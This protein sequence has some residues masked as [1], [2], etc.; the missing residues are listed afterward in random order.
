MITI[1]ELQ[2]AAQE[3]REIRHNLSKLISDMNPVEMVTPLNLTEAKEAWITKAEDG[4][5]E[6]PVFVYDSDLLV[7][8]TDKFGILD[9]ARQKI[10]KIK[11]RNE[12]EEFLLRHYTRVVTDAIITANMAK[13]MLQ[14]DDK[15]L[16]DSVILKY[17]RPVI[18]NSL[19]PNAQPVNVMYPKDQLQRLEN[20]SLDANFIKEIFIWSMEQYGVE[21][22]PV[23]I[24]ENCSAIDVRDKNSGGHP[25]IAIPASRKVNGLKLAELVGHEIECHWRNSQNITSIGCLKTDDE[26]VYEGVAKFKDMA[27]QAK[28]TGE[29][30]LPSIYHV[31]AESMAL[32]SVGFAGVGR[33]LFEATKSAK[34]AWTFTYRAF[35]G[36]ADTTNAVGYAFTK[37]KA[38][39]EGVICVDG[40]VKI[41]LLPYLSFAALCAGDIYDLAH[42]VDKA[43][44][45]DPSVL[46]DLDV[47]SKVL[48]E[49]E[50]RL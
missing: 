47:Q 46:R 23:E 26:V 19:N 42:S 22:W 48:S 31:L 25:M 27:F 34:R 11:P 2:G 16:S 44:I 1:K 12:A 45:F 35:R 24:L 13:A 28:T 30:T 43:S 9:E 5:F 8:I 50:R 49:V 38:Y 6:N 20:V 15:S 39:L 3:Y 7:K 14:K 36:V 37:D 10:S 4:H 21:P 29:A 41:G 33:K 32:S 17:G 18:S 40:M